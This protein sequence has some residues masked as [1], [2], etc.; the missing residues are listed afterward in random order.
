MASHEVQT[1]EVECI[2]CCCCCC[3]RRCYRRCSSEHNTYST[4]YFTLYGLLKQ[5]YCETLHTITNVRFYLHML[6]C[7]PSIF[8]LVLSP[9]F[10]IWKLC[11]RHGKNHCYT[12]SSVTVI[13]SWGKTR[14]PIVHLSN[15]ASLSHSTKLKVQ[16][17]TL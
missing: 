2:N 12:A 15:Q 4:I 9:F 3:L 11:P 1:T 7:F 14:C 17:T 13:V 8:R 6:M 16:T 10:F 5:P